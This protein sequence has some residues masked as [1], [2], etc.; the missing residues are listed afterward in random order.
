MV[1]RHQE[2]KKDPTPETV[3]ILG[4]ILSSVGYGGIPI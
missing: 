1:S 4:F 2:L 3:A